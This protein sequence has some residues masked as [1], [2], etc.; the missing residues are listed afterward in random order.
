MVISML[1]STPPDIDLTRFGLVVRA[2]FVLFFLAPVLRRKKKGPENNSKWVQFHDLFFQLVVRSVV[3]PVV[4]IGRRA[5][6]SLHKYQG[7]YE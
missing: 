1:L 7:T 2:S 6:D 3:N 5:L 4:N